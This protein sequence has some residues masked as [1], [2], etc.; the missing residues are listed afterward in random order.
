MLDFR[1]GTE[2]LGYFH[3]ELAVYR[4]GGQPCAVCAATLAN[5]EKR[6]KQL[7]RVH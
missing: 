2:K 3:Q 4:C 1:D 7:D 5:D 6:Q